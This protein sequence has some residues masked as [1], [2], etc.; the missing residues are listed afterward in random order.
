MTSKLQPVHQKGLNLA[1]SEQDQMRFRRFHQSRF[2]HWRK[3]Q[4]IHA[5]RLDAPMRGF[6]RLRRRALQHRCRFRREIK[7]VAN[8]HRIHGCLKRIVVSD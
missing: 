8:N 5:P 3:F 7:P 6:A 4:H 2:G 1:H